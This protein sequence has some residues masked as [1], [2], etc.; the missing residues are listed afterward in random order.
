MAVRIMFFIASVLES[1]EG[2]CDAAEAFFGDTTAR[3]SRDAAEALALACL[4]CPASSQALRTD[5]QP[6]PTRAA[7]TWNRKTR[8]L[9]ATKPAEARCRKTAS[10]NDLPIVDNAATKLR[11]TARSLRLQLYAL[12]AALSYT[13]RPAGSDK[14]GSQMPLA[15]FFA[16]V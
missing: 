14:S 7:A 10:N 16:P 8:T 12:E 13:E 6:M 5:F 3:T 2:F 15:I 11:S 4:S 9:A 1:S